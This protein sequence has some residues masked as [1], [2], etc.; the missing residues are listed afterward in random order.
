MRRYLRHTAATKIIEAGVDLVTVS[1][2]LGHSSINMTMRYAHP[3]P[4]NMSVAVEKLAKIL[5]DGSP[6][7]DAT[8]KVNH[9]IRSHF[10]RSI[11][12]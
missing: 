5:L 11:L 3:T 12:N 4:E 6:E 9:P 10:H 8:Y 7:E 2:I 1:R